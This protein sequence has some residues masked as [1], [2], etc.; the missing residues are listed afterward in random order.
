M[1]A[2]GNFGSPSNMHLDADRIPHNRRRHRSSSFSRRDKKR[3]QTEY[4]QLSMTCMSAAHHRHHISVPK[5]LQSLPHPH[6]TLVPTLS[7]SRTPTY[8]FISGVSS[9]TTYKSFGCSSQHPPPPK[10]TNGASTSAAPPIRRERMR[11][12]AVHPKR[13]RCLTHIQQHISQR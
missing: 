13:L 12:G 7:T 2:F 4:T 11:L 9:S 8:A 1:Q 5:C 3:R 10:Q 6:Q